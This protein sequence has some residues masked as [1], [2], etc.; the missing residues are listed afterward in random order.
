MF[1]VGE[2][3][4]FEASESKPSNSLACSVFTSA[5]TLTFVSYTPRGFLVG[6]R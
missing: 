2:Q 1:A 4:Q 6:R 5:S 3:E